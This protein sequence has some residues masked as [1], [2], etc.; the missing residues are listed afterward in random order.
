MSQPS[1]T[2]TYTRTE[3]PEAF[4]TATRV[5]PHRIELDL[6]GATDGKRVL[7]VMTG[8]A[9]EL[10]ADIDALETSLADAKERLELDVL[11]ASYDYEGG[12]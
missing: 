5:L 1:L 10:L 6:H 11:Y 12:Q 9:A 4:S 3:L 8:T 2:P 7:V